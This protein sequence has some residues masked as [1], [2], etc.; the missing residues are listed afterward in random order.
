MAE[1]ALGAGFTGSDLQTALHS[2]KDEKA[3]IYSWSP[4]MN[5]SIRGLDE[6]IPLARR[7]KIKLIV[8]LDP[9]C[10]LKQAQEISRLHHWP[11]E[12]LKTMDAKELIEKGFRIHYPSY[13][14]AQNGNFTSPT[15][16]GYKSIGELTRMVRTYLK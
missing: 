12:Y 2:Q 3:V 13:L 4:H 5:L 7:N 1:M 9:N 16:P 11:A 8:V 14:L 6:I 15:I 10:D